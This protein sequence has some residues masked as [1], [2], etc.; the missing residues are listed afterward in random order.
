MTT[1]KANGAT[2]LVEQ[3]IDTSA[4]TFTSRRRVGLG[5]VDPTGRARLDAI[6]SYQQDIANA[7]FEDTQMGDAMAFVL[8]RN[9]V[10]VHAWPR[11][12]ERLD[13]LT[14]AG[15]L[16]PRWAER[17]TTLR[18]ELG[19]H[20]ECAAIWVAVDVPTG[21]PVPLPVRF[22]EFY[23]TAAAGRSVTARLILGDPSSG[24]ASLPWSIR[25]SDLDTLGHVNNAAQW[26]AIEE[27]LQRSPMAPV[28]AA[29]RAEIEHRTGLLETTSG[30]IVDIA[31][32]TNESATSVWIRSAGEIVTAARFQA[33]DG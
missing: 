19:A 12:G 33:I 13:L 25:R 7:D 11:I 27:V 17:R 29:L 3:P 8:R 24:A 16:G 32:E 5:D 4:R 14:W 26:Q 15:G 10:V 2:E 20:V 30:E 1:Q 6:T 28:V 31:Y 23:G 22:E 9:L 18:G 21:R